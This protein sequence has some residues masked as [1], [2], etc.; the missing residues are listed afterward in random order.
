MNF[1]KYISIFEMALTLNRHY[2]NIYIS[3]AFKVA[4]GYYLPEHPLLYLGHGIK[5][6]RC[7]VKEQIWLPQRINSKK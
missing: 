1:I 4:H 2:D 3:Y 6:L 5:G 7:L